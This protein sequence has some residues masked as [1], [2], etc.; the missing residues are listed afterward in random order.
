M[1]QLQAG[2]VRGSQGWGRTA[3]PAPPAP[4]GLVLLVVSMPWAP[5]S[6]SRAG[7]DA[8]PEHKEEPIEFLL[9]LQPN[10]ITGAAVDL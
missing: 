10:R 2:T 5:N 9:I 7:G 1:Q 8:A 3:H 6:C 4:G